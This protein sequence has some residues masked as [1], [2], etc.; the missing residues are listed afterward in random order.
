MLMGHTAPYKLVALGEVAEAMLKGNVPAWQSG[1]VALCKVARATSEAR[2]AR[3]TD[4][5]VVQLGSVDGS[6]R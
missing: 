1:T 2:W 3:W 6:A 4:R 5:L